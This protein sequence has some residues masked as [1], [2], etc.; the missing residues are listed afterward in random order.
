MKRR[1]IKNTCRLIPVIILLLAILSVAQI[2]K[3]SP[4][5]Q[6]LNTY[7]PLEMAI[8]ILNGNQPI[9]INGAK[10]LS[11]A[12]I[13]SGTVIA[14]PKEMGAKVALRSVGALD[15]ASDTNLKLDFDENANVRV[16]LNQGCVT[17]VLTG[18]GS[19]EVMTANGVAGKLSGGSR[20]PLNVCFPQGM[21]TESTAPN[22]PRGSWLQLTERAAVAL[23]GGSTGANAATGLD[24]RGNNPGPTTP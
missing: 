4:N 10:A 5:G 24:D 6:F 3:G 23:I 8:L 22:V 21:R 13:L 18:R 12:T 16:T 11:G 20:E 19:G 14:T 9:S 1:L 2:Q 7:R 17:M 15:I